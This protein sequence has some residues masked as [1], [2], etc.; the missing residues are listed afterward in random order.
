MAK[1][2][3][4]GTRPRLCS[5]N[6]PAVS[7]GPARRLQGTARA[8]CPCSLPG[9]RAGV[10]GRFHGWT[11]DSTA[12]PGKDQARCPV[13][14]VRHPGW[15]PSSQLGQHHTYVVCDARLYVGESG[16]VVRHRPSQRTRTPDRPRPPGVG[17]SSEVADIDRPR[18]SQRTSRHK[19]P[20]AAMPT[21]GNRVERLVEGMVHPP[22]RAEDCLVRV[23][24]R[25]PL[26][27]VVDH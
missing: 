1:P 26:A 20:G 5:R 7:R 12:S 17:K 11:R 13:L 25:R 24:P 15:V 16:V 23:D 10:H 22:T 3:A 9:R 27:R 19:S 21:D 18:A 6:R 8:A 2:M 14:R 4:P